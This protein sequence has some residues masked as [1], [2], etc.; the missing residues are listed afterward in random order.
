MITV[1]DA[2]ELVKDD[3]NQVLLAC[4]GSIVTGFDWR[5]PVMV[6][7]YGDYLIDS[8][9]ALGEDDFEL[10]LAMQ[11]MRRAGA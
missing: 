4:A 1:R 10:D 9:H 3:A 8:I 6:D 2:I 7:A 11:M 5:N